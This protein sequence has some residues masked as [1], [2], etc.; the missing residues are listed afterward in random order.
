MDIDYPV[1]LSM[2]LEPVGCPCVTVTAGPKVFSQQISART[3]IDFEFRA[4][5]SFDLT[6]ELKNKDA[7][8]PHT[9]VEIKNLEIFGIGH[10]KFL[11]VGAYHPQYPDHLAH[12][13]SVIPSQ[14]YLSW[15]GCYRLTIAVPVFVW[16]HQTLNMGWL[17]R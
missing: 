1:V 9:A 14:T 11:W 4:Q 16:I 10:D 2:V 17:Y 3:K 6:V 7:L 8:D 13:P 5:G 15:N 12:Q